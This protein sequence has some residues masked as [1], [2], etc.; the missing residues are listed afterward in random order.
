MHEETPVTW[1]MHED[2]KETLNKAA[3]IIKELRVIYWSLE[4]FSQLGEELGGEEAVKNTLLHADAHWQKKIPIHL[5]GSQCKLQVFLHP[6][7]WGLYAWLKWL[8][9]L[10]S[11]TYPYKA[12]SL[13]S[14]KCK[15]K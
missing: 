10:V 1:G 11:F 6:W 4:F 8:C 2:L 5:T 13:H 12:S 15:S 3:K 9:K 7:T 14:P